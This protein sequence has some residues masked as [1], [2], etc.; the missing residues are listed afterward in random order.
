MLEILIKM[1]NEKHIELEFHTVFFHAWLRQYSSTAGCLGR[2]DDFHLTWMKN[3]T[4]YFYSLF[5]I[6]FCKEIVNTLCIECIYFRQELN[7]GI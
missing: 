3:L 1:Q 4:K 5:M 7:I 6:L 2:Y